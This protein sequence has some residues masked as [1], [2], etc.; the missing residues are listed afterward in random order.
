MN[1]GNNKRVYRFAET[2]LNAA[3]LA[4]RTG[5]DG[6]AYL[7][8]VRDIRGCTDTD[9]SID[10]IIEERH[11]EFVGEGKRY[12]D[13]VRTGKAAQVLTAAKRTFDKSQPIDWTENKKYWPIPQAEIDKTASTEHPIVQNNY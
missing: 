7:K 8:Q 1:Y 3:E 10:G 9:T 13:L 6:S 4:A 5:S 2:L 12:W 11:K